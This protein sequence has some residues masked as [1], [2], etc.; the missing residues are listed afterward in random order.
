MVPTVDTVRYD[1]LVHALINVGRP[2]LLCGPV[3]TG[4][5]S[6]AG[7]VLQKLDSTKFNVL[8]INMSAQVRT[9]IVAWLLYMTDINAHV[10]LQRLPMS[11][12]IFWAFGSF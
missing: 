9:R 1:F 2:V 5:T 8:M 12:E 10:F 4:K 3:G 6:V 11:V 7:G